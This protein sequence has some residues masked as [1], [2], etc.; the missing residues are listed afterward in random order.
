MDPYAPDPELTPVDL[1]DHAYRYRQMADVA[2]TQEDREAMTRLAWQY[3]KLA[4]EK[5]RK[6]S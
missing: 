4:I 2:T 3:E 1:L 5:G 6:Q